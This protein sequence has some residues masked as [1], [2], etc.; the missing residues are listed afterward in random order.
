MDSAAFRDTL[1]QAIV[2]A[3]EAVQI[4]QR[5]RGL[6]DR[7]VVAHPAVVEA[8][9]AVGVHAPRAPLLVV[10]GHHQVEPTVLVDIAEVDRVA[11]EPAAERLPGGRGLP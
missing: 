3:V 9:A 7:S 4:G 11:L 6:E 5:H 10:V 8:R 2:E 1:K